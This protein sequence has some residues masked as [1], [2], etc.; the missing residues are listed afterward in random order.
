VIPIKTESLL[1]VSSGIDNMWQDDN[2]RG[3]ASSPS[4]FTLAG[5]NGGPADLPG[6]RSG[7]PGGRRWRGGSNRGGRQHRVVKVKKEGDDASPPS[8]SALGRSGGKEE[9]GAVVVVSYKMT[10]NNLTIS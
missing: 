8:S 7:A 9:R 5:G 3:N 10:Y 6:R 1:F 4:F 2:D